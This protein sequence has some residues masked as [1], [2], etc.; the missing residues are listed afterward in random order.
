VKL[1]GAVGEAG[2]EG[3]VA[4]GAEPGAAAAG[5]P[6]LPDGDQFGLEYPEGGARPGVG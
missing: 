2:D 4:A 3:Y 1:P 5:D 6:G